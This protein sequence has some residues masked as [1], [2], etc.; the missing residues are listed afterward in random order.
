MGQ[1]T[2]RNYGKMTAEEL[3]AAVNLVKSENSGYSELKTLEVHLNNL[4]YLCI[5]SLL[6]HWFNKVFSYRQD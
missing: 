6:Q 4:V 3:S 1:K 5:A 2:K